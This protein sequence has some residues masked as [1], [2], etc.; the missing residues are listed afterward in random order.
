MRHAH[1]DGDVAVV[2]KPDAGGGTEKLAQPYEKPRRQEHASFPDA[3]R[4]VYGVP[5]LAPGTRKETL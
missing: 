4:A 2:R 5:V 1:F 3:T